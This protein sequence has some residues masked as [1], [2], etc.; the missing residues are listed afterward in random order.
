MGMYLSIFE[1]YENSIWPLLISADQYVQTRELET[2]DGL[3]SRL[4]RLSN[5][6]PGPSDL[7]WGGPEDAVPATDKQHRDERKE[8]GQ[9]FIKRHT[10]KEEQD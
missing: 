10:G 3:R 5:S 9:T 8:L 4:L 7:Q 6:I 1:D 2:G